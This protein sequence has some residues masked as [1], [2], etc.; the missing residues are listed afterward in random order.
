MI[1]RTAEE[2]TKRVFFCSA[3][4]QAGESSRGCVEGIQRTPRDAEKT[5]EQIRLSQA[6]PGLAKARPCLR[7]EPALMSIISVAERGLGWDSV[8]IALVS[9]TSRNE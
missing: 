6:W 7:Q 8:R 9:P 3:L 5:A 2:R 4:A 1:F